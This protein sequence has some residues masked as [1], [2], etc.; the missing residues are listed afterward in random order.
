MNKNLEIINKSVNEIREIVGARCAHISDLPKIIQA[1]KDNSGSGYSTVFV[2]SDNSFLPETPSA[3]KLNIETGLLE[4]LD[5][6]WSQ[7]STKTTITRSVNN[8]STW[9][10]FSI[11]NHIGDR[12]IDWSTPTDLKGAPGQDGIVGE[13]GPAGPQGP[14]G[15]KGEV[16]SY[17]T[18][19][20]YTGTDTD[21]SPFKPTGGGWD[22][23]S[24]KAY[25]PTSMDGK[26]I[27]VLNSDEVVEDY[28]WLS[29]ATFDQD[30][31]LINDWCSPIRMSGKDGKNGVDGQSIEFIYRLLPNYETYLDLFE[32]LSENKLY[33]PDE[34]GVVPPNNDNLNIDTEWTASPSGISQVYPIEVVCTRTKVDTWGSWSN[35]VMWSKW[36]EDGTDGDGVEYIYLITEPNITSE[37]VKDIYMPNNLEAIA[38]EE[39]YQQD[40]FCFNDDWGYEGY[41][42]TDEPSD[43]GPGKPLEWVSVRKYR[44]GKWEVFSDPKLWAKY[45][46]DGITYITSFV[47]TR[48]SVDNPPSKPT[49][50]SYSRPIPDETVWEDSV[51]NSIN[52]LPVWMS[53]RTFASGGLNFDDDWTEPK[54]LTDGPNFQVEYCAHPDVTGDKIDK[55]TGDI[56]SWRTAQLRYGFEWGDDNTITDPI[57]MIT[58]SSRGG[59][60]SDWTLSRIK[61]EKGEKGDAGSS[62]A[63]EGQFDTKESLLQAWDK[64]VTTNDVSGFYFESQDNVINQG[65]GW[66]VVEEGLLYTYSGGWNSE[67]P[68]SNFDLYWFS[69]PIKGEPGDNAYLYIAYTDGTDDTATLYFD[70]PKKYIGIKYS[71]KELSPDEKN[72]YNT[73]MWS[74]WKGEDGWGQEQIFLLTS[75]ALG[76]NPDGEHLPLPTDNQNVQDY[77]P[78]HS[79]GSKAFPT[80]RWSDSPLTVTEHLPYC[81]VAIRKRQGNSFENWKGYNNKAALYSRYS[82]DGVSNVKVDLTNDLAVIPVE[83]GRI[84]PDFTDEVWTNVKVYVGDEEI[85]SDQFGVYGEK[86]TIEGSK[87][88]LNLEEIDEN[89]KEIILTVTLSGKSY[90]VTWRILQTSTAYELTPNTYVLKRY[91][92]GELSGQLSSP[93][94]IVEISK[95]I[96]NKWISVNVPVFAEIT[97]TDSRI[98]I[99]STSDNKVEVS[100]GKAIVDLNGLLNVAG[101][102]IYIVQKDSDGEYWSDG[103]VLSFENISIV[104]DGIAGGNGGR[105]IFLYTSSAS[106]ITHFV[107]TPIGGTW[108]IE[109]N[110]VENVISGDSHVWTMS[111]PHTTSVDPYVWQTVGNFNAEGQLTGVWSEPICI[112]GADGQPGKDGA[113]VEFIYRRLRNKTEYDDLVEILLDKPLFITD[114]GKVPNKTDN[115]CPTDWTGNPT[116]IE[117]DIYPL[118]VTCIRRTDA[119]GNWSVWYP[120]TI[121]AMWGEDG[122]DGPGFEYIFKITA[123]DMTAE[124]LDIELNAWREHRDYQNDDFVPDDWTD[125]PLDVSSEKP[126]EWVSTRKKIDGVWE[127]FTKP[128]LWG[129]YVEDGY[130]FKT[131]Y[132]FTRS[133][134]PPTQPGNNIGD[135]QTP[136]PTEGIWKD[137][138]PEG[139]DPIWMCYRAF[140]SD[141]V[142]VDESWSIPVR[143]GDSSNVQIEF[144]TADLSTKSNYKPD[145]FGNYASEEEWRAHEKEQGVDWLDDVPNAY[146]M[147][148]AI[149]RNGKWE[150]WSVTRVKGEKGE[151]GENGTSI[152][153]K[154]KFESEDALRGEWNTYINSPSS[155][156]GGLFVLPMNTGDCYTVGT[157]LWVYD[158]SGIEFDKAWIDI[159]EF[160]GESG[161]I[162]V[163]F[164][165]NPDGADMF[166]PENIGN[167]RPKYIGVATSTGELDESSLNNPD[168]FKP[169]VK[170]EGDDGFGFEQ[171][172]TATEVYVAPEIPESGKAESEYNNWSDSPISVSETNRYVWYVTRKVTGQNG[173]GEWKGDNDTGK[174]ALWDRWTVDGDGAVNFELSQDQIVIPVEIDGSIDADFTSTQIS[175]NV[176]DGGTRVSA[177]YISDPEITISEDGVAT[178]T[179][180]QLEGIDHITFTATYKDFAH[181][182][183]CQIKKTTNAYEIGTNVNALHKNSDGTIDATVIVYPKKWNG[184]KWSSVINNELFYKLFTVENPEGTEGEGIEITE[185]SVSVNVNTP[186][187]TKIRFYLKDGENELCYEE[188]GVYADGPKGDKGDTGDVGEPGRSIVSVKEFYLTSS[189]SS[190]ITVDPQEGWAE[191]NPTIPLS[192]TNRYLWNYTETTYS[193][194]DVVSS[195]PIIVGGFGSDAISINLSNEFGRM[196]WFANGEVSVDT[197]ECA[198]TATRNG[199]PLSVSL[200]YDSYEFDNITIDGSKITLENTKKL[201]AGIYTQPIKITVDGSDFVRTIT[202]TVEE[203]PNVDVDIVMDQHVELDGETLSMK[204]FLR[205]KM[206]VQTYPYPHYNTYEYTI[207]GTYETE[208]YVRD[209]IYTS[210]IRAVSNGFDTDYL[211]TNV[212]LGETVLDKEHWKLDNK[213]LFFT[214]EDFWDVTFPCAGKITFMVGEMFID[215]DILFVKSDSY[216]K[217]LIITP[218]TLKQ[219]ESAEVTFIVA[220]ASQNGDSVRTVSLKELMDSDVRLKLYANGTEVSLNAD[221]KYSI[222]EIADDV[223]FKVIHEGNDN[224]QIVRGIATLHVPVITKTDYYT[225]ESLNPFV[226]VNE[227]A[228]INNGILVGDPIKLIIKHH[229]GND[230]EVLTEIPDGYSLKVNDNDWFTLT[231]N[232][233]DL[234]KNTTPIKIELFDSDVLVDQITIEKTVVYPEPLIY[235][236][237]EWDKDGSFV[238]NYKMIPYTC[239][240]N[241]DSY[242]YY[243]GNIDVLKEKNI[244]EINLNETSANNGT[245]PADMK[246]ESGTLLWNPM[247]SYKAIYADIGVFKQAKVGPLVFYRDCVFSQIGKF[248]EVT[249]EID[250]VEYTSLEL[251]DTKEQNYRVG[252]LIEYESVI[253]SNIRMINSSSESYSTIYYTDLWSYVSEGFWTPNYLLNAKTG[254]LTINSTSDAATTLQIGD[255][256]TIGSESSEISIIDFGVPFS[257]GTMRKYGTLRL[258]ADTQ[259]VISYRGVDYGNT[260]TGIHTGYFGVGHGYGPDCTEI[261][262]GGFVNIVNNIEGLRWDGSRCYSFD[263]SNTPT[264]TMSADAEN[265]ALNILSGQTA[266]LRPYIGDQDDLYKLGQTPSCFTPSVYTIW[267]ECTIILPNP[268]ENKFIQPGDTFDVWK[269]TTEYVVITIE[270]YSSGTAAMFTIISD[271]NV[272][273]KSTHTW[274]TPGGYKFI[275]TGNNGWLVI[276]Q[277]A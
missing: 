55:F 157:H 123:N 212:K 247:D 271:E 140:R 74:Q 159:G 154:G 56:D 135:F 118:E 191:N 117:K 136:Y 276:F 172:F 149:S 61:G 163:R 204:G 187:L 257:N 75:E 209:N 239:V 26:T 14:R 168:N 161:H 15:E 215:K 5:E 207:L 253:N 165:E 36:G 83:K 107:K 70:T 169:W 51:P 16:V 251:T 24:N 182:K 146:Y 1:L 273:T 111:T 9:M 184:N 88:I 21:R 262:G 189:K 144:T 261:N 250:G 62:V 268:L 32:H 267:S 241:E 131:S 229:I 45:A 228:L 205:D 263:S 3:S 192:S 224:K 65:D 110:E 173:Y 121:W 20:A 119:N 76:F 129:K 22:L 106:N 195:D 27:W 236:A 37:K 6:G 167:K 143:M 69:T 150:D 130:A 166:T 270:P 30:G 142:I 186:N 198:V 4:D 126:F 244:S 19:F 199:E 97:Y 231:L 174:A 233:T 185:T 264:L 125:E 223:E 50:G 221:G 92:E 17:R 178:I 104:A 183:V 177:D 87:V 71:N 48:A 265:I 235:S 274:K 230:V 148:T 225:I 179:R 112:T 248:N 151:T 86:V 77:L 66:Y 260:D 78:A 79:Y 96:D 219:G 128:A 245:T 64:Y 211:V 29:Q 18:V 227:A 109:T 31:T 12:V 242:D 10:S 44:N 25:P 202:V 201:A 193:N 47:F 222:N 94:L 237:G 259:Q 95:W 102:K 132:I 72:T 93:S 210:I 234:Y 137:S 103:E 153:I 35:C 188:V 275:F 28:I 49:G 258:G 81:W 220:S 147:A 141:N 85:P 7:T 90:D 133:V 82:Y 194:G 59:V 58:A 34:K 232:S 190:G 8:T 175:L 206:E 91:V 101:I 171:M 120:P 105:T 256:I 243:V 216:F 63:I 40:G 124:L 145:N 127:P 98:E 33:S 156:E 114:T 2:F 158:G 162:Y 89:T 203:L 139:N 99:L 160:H 240:K 100:N 246:L 116:G 39:N 122:N 255:S 269:A 46:E 84:D 67:E 218:S 214:Y 272:A 53:T 266:G 80:D 217:Q 60:W 180:G 254:Q 13:T 152:T 238:M 68:N 181:K 208:A 73:Y 138:V 197:L 11:F 134:E 115:I 42:W 113:G 252:S 277:K 43:V 200:S 226:Q 196:A 155:Y 57:W 41:D 52:N 164:S 38:L 249:K 170:W 108:N 54:I 176:Y 23:A 213:R